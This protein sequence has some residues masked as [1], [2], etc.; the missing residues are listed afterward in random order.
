MRPLILS[1]TLLLA[2]AGCGGDENGGETDA[3]GRT[4]VELR[5]AYDDGAGKRKQGTL[6]C[7]TG[8]P[9]A[10]GFLAGRDPG[11]LCRSARSLRKLLTSQPD[12]DQLCTQ[13]YGGP[14]TAHVLGS[15]GDAEVDRRFSRTNGCRI[16]EWD[17]LTQ[18]GLLPR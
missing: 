13:I 18:A 4:T 7:R 12:P 16:E 3:P 11:K 15:I 17:R 14:Q 9:R 6:E 8:S 10:E 1:T 2:A 5:I